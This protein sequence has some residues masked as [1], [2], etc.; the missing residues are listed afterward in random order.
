MIL[1][2]I[3]ALNA[4]VGVCQIMKTKIKT[5]DQIV[6]DLL[7]MS[8][9]PYGCLLEHIHSF[10]N[11]TFTPLKISFH[12]NNLSMQ[13]SAFKTTLVCNLLK[14]QVHCECNP[15]AYGL[16]SALHTYACLSRLPLYH[17]VV[18]TT[19]IHNICVGSN[20]NVSKSSFR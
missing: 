7:S 2:I 8:C 18:A 14:N 19:F 9:V 5:R 16:M 4:V 3:N 11:D 1:S 15:R 10:V 20:Y 17:S 13:Y 6:N 12:K